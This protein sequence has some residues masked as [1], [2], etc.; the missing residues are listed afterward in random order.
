MSTGIANVAAGYTFKAMSAA[1][2]ALQE[3][4]RM[5]RQLQAQMA[6][7]SKETIKSTVT[8]M[9]TSATKAGN[10]LDSQSHAEWLS[11]IV[12]AVTTGVSTV[13]TGAGFVGKT[14][15]A[16][17]ELDDA[18][19]FKS[20]LQ[21]R[22]SGAKRPSIVYQ[23]EDLVQPKMNLAKN[24]DVFGSRTYSQ[25]DA[26]AMN[27]NH[28]IPHNAR[29]DATIANNA[30]IR[31]ENDRIMLENNRRVQIW[32]GSADRDGDV[33]NFNGSDADYNQRA[34]DSITNKED[35]ETIQ[36]N[37]EKR[38]SDL[39]SKQSEQV[40]T[41]ANGVTNL[42]NQ[43]SNTGSSFANAHG[44]SERATFEQ[45][46][47]KQDAIA[48]ALKTLQ[49]QQDEIRGSFQQQADGA[50]QNAMSILDQLASYQQIVA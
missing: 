36:A 27:N 16:N 49:Q 21:D 43:V 12:G 41:K 45:S 29:V 37:V 8:S 20:E 9:R 39:E 14:P 48:T 28:I 2:K 10:A 44:T 33:R 4:S 38:I 17:K 47:R 23:P 42:A 35:L 32:K 1:A 30:R 15:F 11:G 50:F 19:S 7:T 18:R 24:G 13:A 40:A 5:E 31:A 34:L 46:S 26:D 22:L 3:I 25:A 6:V